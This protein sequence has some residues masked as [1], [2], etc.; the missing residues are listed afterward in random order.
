MRLAMRLRASPAHGREIQIDV[1]QTLH[2]RRPLDHLHHGRLALQI[3]PEELRR[4]PNEFRRV[5]NRE[6]VT[7]GLHG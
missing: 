5:A 4:R 3:R 7:G 6:V 1:R 2:G